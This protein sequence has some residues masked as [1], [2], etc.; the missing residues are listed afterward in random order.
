MEIT[1]PRTF[2]NV[3]DDVKQERIKQE[4]EDQ[5]VQ[6]ARK[7]S[8]YAIV[9]GG[10]EIVLLSL[11]WLS[12]PQYTQIAGYIIGVFP[13]I[14]AAFFFPVFERQQRLRLWSYLFIICLLFALI[15]VPLLLPNLLPAVTIAYLLAYLLSNQLLGD[16]GSRWVIPA[17][18]IGFITTYLLIDTGIPYRLFAPLDQTLS[19]LISIGIIGVSLISCAVIVRMFLVIQM[20]Q[21]QQMHFANFE[22]EERAAAEQQQREAIEQANNEIEQRI[23]IELHQRETLQTLIEQI[24]ESAG[25][26]NSAAAE[27]QA[28]ATQQVTA[29][30][31]QETAVTQTVATVE[32]VRT[33]GPADRRTR[34][35]GCPYRY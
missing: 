17:S 9:A 14:I 10:V 3:S 34:S 7:L 13:I 28:A 15:I 5:R 23:T 16:K 18:T 8:K 21:F 20:K 29:T 4:I 1:I 25:V 27:M 33:T 19:S 26:L 2:S 11:F 12:A 24:R 30:L 32:E 22:I 31:E 6:L 35:T